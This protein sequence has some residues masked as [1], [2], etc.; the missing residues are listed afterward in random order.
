MYVQEVARLRSGVEGSTSFWIV[1]STVRSTSQSHLFFR[2][3]GQNVIVQCYRDMMADPIPI[4]S[5]ITVKYAGVYESSGKLKRPFFWRERKEN[6]DSGTIG[7]WIS[8]KDGSEFLSSFSERRGFE[9]MDD[10]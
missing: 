5:T 7:N 3:N 9:F 6:S 2:E 4:G 10:W 1:L 8:T